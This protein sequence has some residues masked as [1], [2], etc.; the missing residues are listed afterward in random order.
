MSQESPSRPAAWRPMQSYQTLAA[1]TR[2]SLMLVAT[3]AGE[4]GDQIA[5]AR[6]CGPSLGFQAGQPLYLSLLWLVTSLTFV[7]YD[8]DLLSNGVC[9]SQRKIVDKT[10]VPS[11]FRLDRGFMEMSCA[12]AAPR[13]LN[14]QLMLNV[15][16]RKEPHYVIIGTDRPVY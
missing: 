4:D 6:N 15:R 10:R 11:H 12:L 8:A 2:Q 16:T 7:I 5:A 1:R 9:P 14:S 3:A 13:P